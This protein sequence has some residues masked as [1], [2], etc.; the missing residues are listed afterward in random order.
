[1]TAAPNLGPLEA[2]IMQILWSCEPGEHASVRDVLGH[3]GDDL[4][5]TT[6][7]TVLGRLHDKGLAERRK[8][9]RGWAY[10]PAGTADGYAAASMRR[11]L[12]SAEDR[13]AALLR[14]AAELDQDEAAALR[15]LL[16]DHAG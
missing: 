6:V 3:L 11:V 7:M 16:E 5:Y 15:R 2:R 1:M 8:V 13:T 12:A 4:A 9:G 14:F 10:T